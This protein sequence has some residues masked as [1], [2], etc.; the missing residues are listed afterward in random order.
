MLSIEKKRI[1]LTLT[2]VY[3]ETLDRLVEEGIYMDYQVV[4]RDA[5]RHLFLHHKIEPFCTELVGEAE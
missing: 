1:S 4:I 5:L 3:V 2:N